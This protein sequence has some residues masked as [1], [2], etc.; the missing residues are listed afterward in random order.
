MARVVAYIPDLLFGSRVQAALLADG[1]TAELVGDAGALRK[2]LP[3]AG[4]LVID[5]TDDVSQRLELAESLSGEGLLDGT[6]TLVFY[7]HVEAETRRRAEE[8][9]FDLV[10][11][12]SRMA[13]EGAALVTRLVDPRSGA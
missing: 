4:A 1:H 5:L 9:G 6:R 3:G 12:R 2:A 7:S 8:A 11:P 10:I 13:R